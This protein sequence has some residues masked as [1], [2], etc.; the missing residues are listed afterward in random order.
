MSGL[1]SVKPDRLIKALGRAGFFV[2]HVTGGHYVL[3]HPDRPHVRLVV[4]HH[5]GDVKR[6]VLRSILHQAELTVEELS[7]LL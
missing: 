6:G 1:P 5:S 2:H 7:K 4:P 3:K